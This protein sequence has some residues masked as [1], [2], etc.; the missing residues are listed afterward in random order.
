MKPEDPEIDLI[1]NAA[2]RLAQAL[3]GEIIPL[4]EEPT[5]ISDELADSSELEE[6]DEDDVEF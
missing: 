5:E 4:N 2:R 1:M 6:L 3:D